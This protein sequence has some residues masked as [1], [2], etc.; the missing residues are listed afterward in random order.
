ME[1]KGNYCGFCCEP[2]LPGRKYCPGD[3]ARNAA[4]AKRLRRTI[5]ECDQT[6]VEEFRRRIQ[7]AVDGGDVT[8]REGGCDSVQKDKAVDAGIQ[9]PRVSRRHRKS[10]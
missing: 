6:N 4:F 5:D 10:G 9:R 3:C 8:T 1:S 2:L 7:N